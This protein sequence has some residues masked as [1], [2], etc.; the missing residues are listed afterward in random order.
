MRRM[1]AVGIRELRDHVTAVMRRVKDGEVV[2][3]TDRGRTI[4]RIVPVRPSGGY[5]KL[6]A[7]GR[8]RPAEGDLLDIRPLKA[9]PGAPLPS[10]VLEEMRRDER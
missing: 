4:A 1:A 6:L 2:E 5:E 8:I 9:R 10:Q 7:E 3:V